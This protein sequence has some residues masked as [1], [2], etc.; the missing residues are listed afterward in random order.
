MP[1]ALLLS[2]PPLPLSFCHHRLPSPRYAFAVFVWEILHWEEPF[3]GCQP[4]NAAMRVL[5]G[6][7]PVIDEERLSTLGLSGMVGVLQRAWH[8]DPLQRPAFIDLL[9]EM[10]VVLEEEEGEGEEGEEGR[11]GGEKEG[12]NNE[13]LPI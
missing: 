5:S 13:I 6:E 1:V 2:L 9:S 4:L 8:Q 3:P 10:R 7:R 11:E 12:R